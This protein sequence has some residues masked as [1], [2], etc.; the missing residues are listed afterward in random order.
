MSKKIIFV[1]LGNNNVEQKIVDSMGVHLDK[2]LKDDEATAIVTNF[3]VKVTEIDVIK[4][5]KWKI[6][7]ISVVIGILISMTIQVGFLVYYHYFGAK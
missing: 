6:D 7:D 5:P 2:I 1:E 4:K 3:P